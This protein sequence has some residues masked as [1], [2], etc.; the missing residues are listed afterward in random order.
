MGV[1]Q[2]ARLHQR[3]RTAAPTARPEPELDIHPMAFGRSGPRATRYWAVQLRQG[4]AGTAATGRYLCHEATAADAKVAAARLAK[5]RRNASSY[6]LTPVDP[7]VGGWGDTALPQMGKT[8][9][10]TNLYLW[11]RILE[12]RQRMP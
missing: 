9:E 7:P 3:H 4:D 6:T 5:N 11:S 10:V 8:L 12:G 2:A 1:R